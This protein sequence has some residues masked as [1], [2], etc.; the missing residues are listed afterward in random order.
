MARKIVNPTMKIIELYQ[1]KKLRL[2]EDIGRELDDSEDN[3]LLDII[4]FVSI[5]MARELQ[6]NLDN[7]KYND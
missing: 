7:G 5:R 2:I 6:E 1:E 4:T 3:M